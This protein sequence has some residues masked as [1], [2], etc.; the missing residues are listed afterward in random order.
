MHLLVENIN[1]LKEIFSELYHFLLN[2]YFSVFSFN[3]ADTQN[4]KLIKK[5]IKVLFVAWLEIVRFS[6]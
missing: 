1:F 4:Y 6:D 2:N 3:A 5:E